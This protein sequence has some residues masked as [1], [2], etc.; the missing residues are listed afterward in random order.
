MRSSLRVYRESRKTDLHFSF[1]FDPHNFFGSPK[2]KESSRQK[3][4]S[5]KKR[6]QIFQF[7]VFYHTILWMVLY[8]IYTD[9]YNIPFAS[10]SP[11]LGYRAAPCT[12]R[13]VSL[14]VS[15][16]PRRITAE[17]Q[18]RLQYPSSIPY[19]QYT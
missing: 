14:F 17:Q 11:S 18:Q 7:F 13:K 8:N 2:K 19:Y 15:L 1:S 4:R 3:K 10:F 12:L 9:S 16:S 6:Q 5:Q